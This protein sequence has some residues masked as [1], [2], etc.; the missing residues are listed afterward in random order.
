ML[1]KRYIIILIILLLLLKFFNKTKNYESFTD[2][3]FYI[4][5]TL[6]KR[7]DKLCEIKPTMDECKNSTNWDNAVGMKD[8]KNLIKNNPD[9]SDYWMDVW[10][11]NDYGKSDQEDGDNCLLGYP[12]QIFYNSPNYD[13]PDIQL[14]K[15]KRITP[16]P[17]PRVIPTP[18]PRVIPTPTPTPRVIPTPTP[19]VIPT[20]T[21]R[22]TP[23]PT[24][25]VT[26]TPTPRV[27]PT[28]TP[29][30]T[31]IPMPKQTPKPKPKLKLINKDYN[32]IDAYKII[33]NVLNSWESS[34]EAAKKF[35][36]RLPNKLDMDFILS[37]GALFE[38]KDMWVPVNNDMKG[39][40][41]LAK[42]PKKDWIQIGNK[43]VEHGTSHVLSK[44][45]NSYPSWGDVNGEEKF[46]SKMIVVIDKMSKCTRASYLFKKANNEDKKFKDKEIDVKY[47]NNSFRVVYT[48]CKDASCENSDDNN[49]VNNC[50]KSELYYKGVD[51]KY[52]SNDILEDIEE[53]HSII[54]F[55]CE[56]NEVLKKPLI[57]NKN[58]KSV[59]I[60]GMKKMGKKGGGSSNFIYLLL[61]G[62][63]IIF[64]IKMNNKKK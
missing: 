30:V 6:N 10:F 13:G 2:W 58:K 18:T 34:L 25:R 45:L 64:L 35:G 9:T 49:C 48:N 26:P 43:D 44:G 37:K 63:I 47:V 36:G 41:I 22:V 19:R 24:P 20:P 57:F 27:T 38:G 8:L 55:K 46:R 39:N 5:G 1:Y 42:L 33:D 52:Y 32:D 60:S 50:K 54:N 16:T 40:D 28:P 4:D 61:I 56:E 31:Y 11:N 12:K 15:R 62:I 14:C 59:F 3:E 51:G 17:T 53:E 29:S 23:T 7:F 21:P